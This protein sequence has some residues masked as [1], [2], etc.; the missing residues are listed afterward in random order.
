[1]G[2]I[3]ILNGVSFSEN[4]LLFIFGKEEQ[5]LLVK[6]QLKLLD[7]VQPG[8]SERDIK[9]IVVNRQSVLCRQY[10]VKPGEFT[11]I[12]TGKD[13]SEKLRTNELLLPAQLFSL[14]DAMPMRKQ[15]MQKRKPN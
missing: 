6:Q 12:L 10:N 2:V 14:I 13:N 1:M 9:I 7:E 8:V 3:A 4:R 15:E 5:A 11:V